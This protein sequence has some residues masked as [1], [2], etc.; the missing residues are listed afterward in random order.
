[1]QNNP[2]PKKPPSV[3]WLTHKSDGSYC[4]NR[5]KAKISAPSATSSVTTPEGAIVVSISSGVGLMNSLVV[6]SCAPTAETGKSINNK[7]K[8]IRRGK[9]ILPSAFS[10]EKEDHAMVDEGNEGANLIGGVRKQRA[11]RP[12]ANKSKKLIIPNYLISLR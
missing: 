7:Q 6:G 2:S 10:K 9:A 11:F 12:T 5:S 4:T 1:M 8:T 3:T